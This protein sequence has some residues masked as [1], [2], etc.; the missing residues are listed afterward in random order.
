MMPDFRKEL[1]LSNVIALAG[2]L[3]IIV[4]AWTT[5][6]SSITGVEARVSD[7]DRRIIEIDGDKKASDANTTRML[8]QI[9]EIRTDLRYLRQA[10]ERDAKN[11]Q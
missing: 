1:T 2:L 7:H 5:L 6:N 11:T 10:M 9:A 8:E 4:G 3:G